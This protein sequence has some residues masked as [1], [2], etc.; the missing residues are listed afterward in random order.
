MSFCSCCCCCSYLISKSKRSKGRKE[1][2]SIDEE[3][4]IM[5]DCLTAC[6][7]E[8]EREIGNYEIN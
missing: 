2:G 3:A 7:K 5:T 4:T 6:L 8:R 1:G